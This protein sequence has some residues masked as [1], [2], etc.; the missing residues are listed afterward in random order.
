MAC[1]FCDTTDVRPEFWDTGWNE[2]TG[3]Y[4]TVKGKQ[5]L[6]FGFRTRFHPAVII[7]RWRHDGGLYFQN[8]F[9]P[10]SDIQNVSWNP[11]LAKILLDADMEEK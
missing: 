2:E 3:F 4:V 11:P 7:A 8:R 9:V 5:V 6:E 1:L 10:W